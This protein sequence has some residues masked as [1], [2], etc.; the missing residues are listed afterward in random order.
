MGGERAVSF[1]ENLAVALQNPFK[2][3]PTWFFAAIRFY[4]DIFLGSST[5]YGAP[6]LLLRSRL[7]LQFKVATWLGS[8]AL[9]VGNSGH[10]NPF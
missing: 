4:D 9:S 6:I 3:S 2:L 7:P 5:Y 1:P 8:A 10:T